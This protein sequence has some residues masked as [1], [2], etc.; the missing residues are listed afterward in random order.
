MQTVQIHQHGGT[1]YQRISLKWHGA[2]VVC[3]SLSNENI[4]AVQ[5]HG[6]GF[7]KNPVCL[8]TISAGIY[9]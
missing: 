1:L 3:Y 8:N 9:A 7:T 4:Y 2:M 6:H 5:A